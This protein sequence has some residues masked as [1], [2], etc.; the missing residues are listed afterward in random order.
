MPVKNPG[1]YP[2]SSDVFYSKNVFI[3]GIEVAL[4]NAPAKGPAT[5]G[6]GAAASGA[7][8]QQDQ[9]Q[10]STSSSSATA[11]TQSA[12]STTSN[13]IDPAPPPVVPPNSGLSG[14]SSGDTTSV[15]LPEQ[16]PE[17]NVALSAETLAT[18]SATVASFVANPD[19]Y[20]MQLTNALSGNI[21]SCFPGTLRNLSLDPLTSI[22]PKQELVPLIA[23]LSVLSSEGLL[24]SWK[25]TGTQGF[26]SNRNIIGLFADLG[27]DTS[28]P[29]FNSDQTPWSMALVNWTLKRTG[30]RYT[31]S[32]D[33]F[34]I[35]NRTS[36]WGATEIA[37][38]NALPGD[39]AVWD[40]GHVNFVNEK[41]E[42][43]K[44]TFIG[45]CQAQPS[46]P[47]IGTIAVSWQDGY[48]PVNNNGSL[49]KIYRPSKV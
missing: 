35:K 26:Q 47:N 43:G 25:E 31:Q 5:K 14:Q 48:D 11:D 24:G 8:Q 7:N 28:I 40:F 37:L 12:E 29:P 1:S 17:A 45:G 39:I 22:A 19:S 2:T 42:D 30:F 27:Y 46:E 34:D 18:Y 6:G 13:I 38:V 21:K 32:V 23:A 15:V 3:N 41:R 44:L 10:T 4:W 9:N 49:L 36:D 16:A 20:R 33:A